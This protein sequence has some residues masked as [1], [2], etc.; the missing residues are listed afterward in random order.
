[1]LASVNCQTRSQRY[2]GGFARISYSAPS[3]TPKPTALWSPTRAG[4]INP[5]NVKE[6]RHPAVYCVASC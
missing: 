1:M 5:I 2:S 6:R 4:E 3:H